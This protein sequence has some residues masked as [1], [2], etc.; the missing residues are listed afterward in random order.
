MQSK[1][2]IEALLT[3]Q[4]LDELIRIRRHLHQFPEPSFEEHNTSA[5]IRGILD[6]WGIAYKFPIVNTGILAWI[7]GNKP[8]KRIAL[9][10]DMDALPINEQTGLD[11][12]SENP[13]VMHACGHDIHMV[14]LLGTIRILDQLKDHIHGEVLFIFQPGEE[15]VP[16]GAKLMLEAG[17]FDGKLPD[18]IIAQHVLPDM[19]AGHVGFKPGI[20]MASSDEIYITVNGKGGHG[21]LPEH[22]NDPVLMA[23]H[24]LI[25][26]Q[27]EINRKSP[28]GVPTV[29]S[30]GK[31]SAEGAVNVI[32]NQVNLEGTF[33]T[34]NED[35]RK[36]AHRL[37][38]KI[39]SGIASSMGG[40][41]LVEIRHGYPVLHNHEQITEEAKK[42]AIQLMGQDH[43]EDMDIRM[44]AEDFAWF[45]QSVPGMMYRLGVRKPGSDKIYPLHTTGFRADESALKTGI[46]LLSFLAVEL[47]KTPPV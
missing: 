33:R 37:I 28:G 34:M 47:L 6:E 27:Q 31:V 19:E 36:E 30:F 15:K 9:R 25:T 2:H 24:I 29:L 12:Q 38:D 5:Y 4:M 35:W 11:Y 10:S 41:C 40:S 26:L 46:S 39:A 18:M 1:G 16:G 13:G 45:A 20:Y 32:P 44:T 43:V 42:K 3:D 8:G 22:I 23:S 14:S 17:I 7:K 21:A